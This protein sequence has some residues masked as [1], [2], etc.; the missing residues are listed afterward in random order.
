MARSKLGS[1]Y[2]RYADGTNSLFGKGKAAVMLKDLKVYHGVYEEGEVRNVFACLCRLETM[3]I[4]LTLAN[5]LTFFVFNL[6]CTVHS[7]HG[8]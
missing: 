2:E 6:F 5:Y 3:I 1:Y 8:R 4:S 7:F